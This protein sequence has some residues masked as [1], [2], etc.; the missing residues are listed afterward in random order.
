MAQ[1]E[2]DHNRM[3]YIEWFKLSDEQRAEWV[4]TRIELCPLDVGVVV[5]KI[6]EIAERARAEHAKDPSLML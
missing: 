1:E 5:D 3:K 4:K 6:T 2:R